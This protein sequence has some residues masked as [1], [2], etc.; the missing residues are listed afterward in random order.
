MIVLTRTHHDRN[1]RRFYALDVAPT[2][3]GEWALIAEWGRIGQSGMVQT[4]TFADE[5]SGGAAQAKRIAVK[6]RRGYQS[7]GTEGVAPAP[8]QFDDGTTR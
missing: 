8:D 6:Q 1:M 4:S 2:L 5:A 7:K 3:F